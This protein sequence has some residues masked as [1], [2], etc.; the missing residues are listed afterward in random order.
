MG[1]RIEEKA[2]LA[3]GFMYRSMSATI[4]PLSQNVRRL[5]TSQKSMFS[6]FD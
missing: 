1:S 4:L 5:R 6:K 2:V 3:F